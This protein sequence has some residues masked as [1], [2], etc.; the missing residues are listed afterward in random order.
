MYYIRLI[1]E[2]LL[3]VF[4]ILTFIATIYYRFKTIFMRF[5][6][7]NER[8][9]GSKGLLA[10]SLLNLGFW[11]IPLLKYRKIDNQLHNRYAKKSNLFLLLF[12]IF[13]SLL[14]LTH[15]VLW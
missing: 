2:T 6:L 11:I 10:E 8:I 15:K 3:G 7:K 12:I 1:Y 4:I 14:L 13:F 5:R 9:I